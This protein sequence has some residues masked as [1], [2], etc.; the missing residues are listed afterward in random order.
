MEVE[1]KEQEGR[2]AKERRIGEEIKRSQGRKKTKEEFRKG[3]RWRIMIE[4]KGK[5][6]E[7]ENVNEE[8]RRKKRWR[9]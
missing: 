2:E 3:N 7:I 4:G 8:G 9:K 5:R 1:G 6:C